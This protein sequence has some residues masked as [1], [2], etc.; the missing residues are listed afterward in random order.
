MD[1]MTEGGALHPVWW[2]EMTRWTLLLG[3][4]I[5]GEVRV[6][7]HGPRCPKLERLREMA[8][9]YDTRLSLYSNNCRIFAAR[10]QRAAD[11]LNAEDECSTRS[12]EWR[13][14]ELL[15]DA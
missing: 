8:E 11:R 4:S 6:R 5:E 7:A 10:M 9:Q 15:A 1:F 3:Q 14:R 12:A 2:D 13:R